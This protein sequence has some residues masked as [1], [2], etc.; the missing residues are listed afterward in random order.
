VKTSGLP[1]SVHHIE[2]LSD[3]IYAVA[4]T[5]LVIELKLPA[6]ELI[7]GNDELINAVGVLFPKFIS[8]II[9]FFVLAM[10][11]YGHHR[12][13]SQVRH[14]S[15]GLAALMI[16]QLAFVSLMPFCSALSGEFAKAIFSQSFYS[17]NMSVLAVF[18]LLIA[19]Y[20]YRHPELSSE[21]MAPAVYRATQVRTLG[22]VVVGALAVGLAMVAPRFGN[23]MYMLMALIMRVSR[24]IEA[25]A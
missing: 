25:R 20:V 9:S 12:T 15:G 8:W 3:G 13:F 5:L 17:A 1:L 18:A 14:V 2:A 19:R 16:S 11:W 6:A 23:M 22:L 10:F 7:H 4:M 21:P 24:R